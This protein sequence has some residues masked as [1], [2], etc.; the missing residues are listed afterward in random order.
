M[1]ASVTYLSR[2]R[3]RSSTLEFVF[4]AITVFR[5]I[6]LAGAP[7]PVALAE[8]GELKKPPRVLVRQVA[9]GAA[10]TPEK[11]TPPIGFETL[12]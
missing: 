10:A 1:H 8:L 11:L 12:L 5:A 3:L 6:I 9:K 4:R 2:L 7:V